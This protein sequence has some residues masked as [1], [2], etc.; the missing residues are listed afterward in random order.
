MKTVQGNRQVLVAVATGCLGLLLMGCGASAPTS[1]GQSAKSS[2]AS[3]S[4]TDAGF[5]PNLCHTL[6]PMAQGL[7]PGQEL[8]EAA[9]GLTPTS[10]LPLQNAVFEKMLPPT[11]V[12]A[13]YACQWTPPGSL[14]GAVENVVVRIVRTD[15]VVTIDQEEAAI[16]DPSGLGVAPMPISGVGDWAFSSYID[17]PAL[18]VGQGNTMV[19]I[20]VEDMTP[21]IS[22]S[23]LATAV[24]TV[25]TALSGSRS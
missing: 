1:S 24:H 23:Q 7:I 25:L 6:G 22:S 8:D 4:T 5:P 2:S 20:N 19:E 3:G 12:T 16:A 13:G 14:A 17:G 21:E 11:K 9:S 15:R 18:Y 10:E